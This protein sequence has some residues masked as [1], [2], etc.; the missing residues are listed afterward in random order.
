V[1]YIAGPRTIVGWSLIDDRGQPVHAIPFDD[2]TAL[3]VPEGMRIERQ[4][5]S[6]QITMSDVPTPEQEFNKEVTWEAGRE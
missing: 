5:A 2:G 6:V 4:Y 1:P 3:R